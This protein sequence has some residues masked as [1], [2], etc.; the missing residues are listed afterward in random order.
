M[1][2]EN[3]SVSVEENTP[4]S[5][6]EKIQISS[7]SDVLLILLINIADDFVGKVNINITLFV[8]GLIVS[9]VLIGEKPYFEG[10]YNVVN[11]S[12][13]SFEEREKEVEA[14]LTNYKSLCAKLSGNQ[15]EQ[16]QLRNIEYIHLKDVHFYSGNTTIP[17]NSSPYWR[18]DLNRVD[19]FCLR[20]LSTP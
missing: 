5:V 4:V 10:L 2:Q 11:S 18:G 17:N 3:T 9:G 12:F 7:H 19:G 13:S 1:T 14:F 16:N 6:E 8:Q 20:N 15:K